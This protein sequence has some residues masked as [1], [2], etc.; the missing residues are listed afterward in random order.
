MNNLQIQII[1]N[2]V[3][4]ATAPIKAIAG[5]AK[6][7]AEKVQYAQKALSGLDKTKNL[8]EKFKALRNETNGFAKALDTA[9]AN[10]KQLQSAVDANTAKFNSITGKLGNATQQL[11]KHKEEVIRLKSVY[12]NMSIPL[13]KGMGF[14]SFNDARASIARQIETQ[15]QAIKDSNEQIKKLKSERKAAEQAVKSTTKALDGEKESINKINKEYKTHV[16]QL[17]KTQEQLQKAGFSTQHFAQS[18]KQLSADIEKANGKLAKHQR[19]LAL[20]ERAQARFARIKAPISSALN[21]GRN[22]AGV[23]VQASIG[24][25][26]IM[27]PIMSMG[28]G[29][30]GMA[31]VAGKFEQF[32]SVLEVTE[33]SSEK[34]KKSFDWVKKFAVDTP[35]NLDEAMEAF[36]RLRAYGMDPTNGLLQTLGDTAAAMG[37][38]VMQAV[39]AI[40]DAITGENERLKE[41]GIKG[42]AI[43]GTNFIE[44]AYTDKNGKQ[45]SARVDKRNRKQIEDTLKRIWNEKYSGAMEKQA[46]TLLGIWAKLDDVWASFQM[47]IM[48]NGAFDWIKEKL[49]FLLNKF[50]ELEQNGELKKWAKD[51]GTVINEVIQGLWDFGQTIFEGVK[52]LAQ[53]ASQ[54]KGA[55]ATMVK[56]AAI[57]GTALIA[58]A[59]LL[60]TLSLVAP[61]LQVLGSTFLWVGKVATTAIWGI[62]KAMFAN[63]ILATIMLI[64]GGLILLWKNWDK[65]KETLIAGWNWICDTFDNNPILNVLLPIVPLIR[66]IIYLINNWES[67]VDTAS[68]VIKGKFESLKNTITELWNS[69]GKSIT[70]TFNKAMEFLGLET[71]INSVSEG[72]TKAV[73]TVITPEHAENIE[74]IANFSW[75]PTGE[76][77][78][79]KWNG[80][81]A[82]NGGKYQPMG[83]YHG[84]E[85]IMTKEATARLGVPLLNALN[86]GKK[87]AAVSML[88]AGVATAAPVKVDNR[89]PLIPRSAVVQQAQQPMTVNININ[90]AAGQ[91]E[92]TIARLVAQELQRVQQ[93]QQARMR[94][95]MTDNE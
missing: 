60:F 89:P 16:D 70:D 8:A 17:K 51:I 71:R 84:G 67:I 52:W 45:R 9:K 87:A 2:S 25:Q 68:T 42:S 65:V 14:K 3:D 82:G 77:S 64:I 11:N 73:T 92:R 93:Q 23:G 34:A 1:L 21:T 31:Q 10:S 4:K 13:A 38:P 39:E 50:D 33:G 85:Y 75:E 24:G 74:R 35:A 22:I 79:P 36:V 41:F 57:A 69:V 81:Y 86:Y 76:Y 58:L 26:Q 63:P 53:F 7:L 88:G 5:N 30:V 49:Q 28:R 44:Y 90:A 91:D 54:N 56:F 12:N 43:K 6:V 27:Q 95:R 20:V 72:V 18:E 32:Q 55:I 62:G 59:P 46:K 78:R 48:E 40:A 15:K 94:S 80:G 66:G 29:V 83:I 37:K 19:M 61:V 47:K